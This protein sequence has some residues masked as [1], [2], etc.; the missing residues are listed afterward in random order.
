MT[1][2]FPPHWQRY[3]AQAAAAPSAPTAA[4]PRPV[5]PARK[6]V[7]RFSGGYTAGSPVTEAGGAA[8]PLPPRP[9]VDHRPPPPEPPR[10]P[11]EYA[12]LTWQMPAHLRAAVIFNLRQTFEW[13]AQY[14]KPLD[15]P[16]TAPEY[17]RFGLLGEQLVPK[18]GVTVRQALRAELRESVRL[19]EGEQPRLERNWRLAMHSVRLGQLCAELAQRGLDVLEEIRGGLMLLWG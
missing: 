10:R 11:L 14:C 1:S 17:K 15:A 5:P 4:K 2:P 16:K 7:R 12:W 19:L 3:F 8:P 18:G 9:P 13:R 6:P